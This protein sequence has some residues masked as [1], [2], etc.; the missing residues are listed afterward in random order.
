M[1][2]NDFFENNS[3]CCIRCRR[4]GFGHAFDNETQQ[5]RCSQLYICA[6]IYIWHSL[7]KV[8]AVMM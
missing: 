1:D 3:S 2:L 4:R 5:S 8:L 6:C 7:H